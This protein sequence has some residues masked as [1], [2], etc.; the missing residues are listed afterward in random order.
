VSFVLTGIDLINAMEVVPGTFG[1]RGHD[2]REDIARFVSV[3]YDLPVTARQ[4]LEIERALREREL[5]W[6]QKRVVTEQVARAREALLREF[7]S[8]GV[9]SGSDAQADAVLRQILSTPADAVTR[10]EKDQQDPLLPHA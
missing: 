4:L 7:K 3:A 2:Y 1:R 6:A 8:W 5:E 10:E 9:S